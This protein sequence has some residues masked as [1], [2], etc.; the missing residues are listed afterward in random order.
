M[1]D[2][3]QLIELRDDILANPRGLPIANGD[4]LLTDAQIADVYNTVG[5]SGES[6]PRTSLS[7]QEILDALDPQEFQA[8]T[9]EQQTA[10]LQLAGTSQIDVTNPVIKI[11]FRQL[12]PAGSASESNVMGLLSVSVS[13]AQ[14]SGWGRLHHLDVANAVAFMTPA[15]RTLMGR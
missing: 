14:A 11:A 3:D 10:A 7:G 6:V 9:A 8:L 15:Q 5:I 13:P 12:V 2:R 1:L 4:G